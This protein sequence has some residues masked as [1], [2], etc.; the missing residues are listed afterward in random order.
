M[1]KRLKLRGDD[2][3]WRT[4]D[5]ELIAIDV[6]DSTYLSANDSGLLMWNALAVGT[7]KEDLVASLVEAYGI[8]PENAGADV[9]AFLAD[10]KE[11]RLLDEAGTAD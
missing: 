2:L 9:D 3:A 7:T 8:E 5:D 10:L 6:R 1:S 11:R 4:V